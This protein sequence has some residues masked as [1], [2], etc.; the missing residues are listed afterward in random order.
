MVTKDHARDAPYVEALVR[1]IA[2][3]AELFDRGRTVEQLHWGGGTPTFLSH[4]EMVVL[5]DATRRYFRLRDDDRGEYGIE[6]DPRRLAP[7][8]LAL[9]RRLGFNWLSL[10]VQDFDPRVERAVNR[11]QS[12]AQTQAV[13]E[14]TRARS[15]STRSTWT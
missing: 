4:A 13:I 15:A 11:I 6:V 7:G 1:E 5:M 9:L 3:Q 8:T 14:Q 12:V 2:L 10:G